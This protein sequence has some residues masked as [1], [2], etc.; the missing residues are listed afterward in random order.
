VSTLKTNILDTPSGS[1]N[2]TVNRPMTLTA[3]DIVTA[4]LAN[5]AVT[6]AKVVDNA[7][8]IAKMAG[9]TDGQIITYDASGDPVAVGP[10]TSGQVLTSAGTGAPPTF[11]AG[12]KM[13]QVVHTAYTANT[14]GTTVLP[15]DDS[16]PTSTE[17]IPVPGMDTAITPTNASNILFIEVVINQSNSSSGGSSG[18]A[19]FQ[20]S[21]AAA[22]GVGINSHPTAQLFGQISLHYRMVA[23]TTSSTTFKIR[24]GFNGAGTTGV[25]GYTSR[26]YG[27]VAMSTMTITEVAV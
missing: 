8:T 23:G 25:N 5:D 21:G 14:S 11:S 2:I 17:G 10:G 27:G 18:C 4:D 15:I 9:G 20:D 1:G 6:T 24:V 16:I 13:I 22:I 3:G 26:Y 7:I 19:L 12:G